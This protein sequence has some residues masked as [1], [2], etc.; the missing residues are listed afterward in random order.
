[1]NIEVNDTSKEDN[2]LE[3]INV[4]TNE[5]VVKEPIIKKKEADRENIL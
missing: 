5:L 4:V 3:N 1:M 2:F